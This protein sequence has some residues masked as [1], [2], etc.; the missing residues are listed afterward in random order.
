MKFEDLLRLTQY[1]ELW[2]IKPIF[3]KKPALDYEDDFDTVRAN[4]CMMARVSEVADAEGMR[5]KHNYGHG[6]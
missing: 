4:I 3:L 5:S 2:R 6:R 1:R